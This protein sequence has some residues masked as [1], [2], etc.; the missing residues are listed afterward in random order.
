MAMRLSN[1]DDNGE[2][3]SNFWSIYVTE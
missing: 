1:H 3:Q 2:F